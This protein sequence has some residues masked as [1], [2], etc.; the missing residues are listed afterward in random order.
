MRCRLVKIRFM[1]LSYFL[2]VNSILLFNLSVPIVAS[3]FKGEGVHQFYLK[4][5]LISNTSDNKT[6]N[7]NIIR[8]YRVKGEPI[9]LTHA[10]VTSNRAIYDLGEYLWNQG[11]D[12]WMPNMRSHGT[13]D[14]RSFVSPYSP[15]DYSFDSIVT[16]DWPFLLDYVYKET[17]KKV[18]IVGHSM[19]A[20]TWEQCLSGT[21]KDADGSLYV[22]DGLIKDRSSKVSSFTT[23][24]MPPDL[25]EVRSV[26]KSLVYP[27][28]PLLERFHIYVPFNVSAS[29]KERK[30]S[31]QLIRDSVVSLISPY[32]FFILP[33]GIISPKNCSSEEFE[34]L[35]LK[36]LS[37]AHSDYTSD[38][39][40]WMY[41]KYKSRDGG[42]HYDEN[43]RVEVPT[44]TITASEDTLAPPNYI[45]KAMSRYPD[46]TPIRLVHFIGAAHLDIILSKIVTKLG[47]EIVDFYKNLELLGVREEKVVNL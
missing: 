34:D 14:Q 9:I 26:I 35:V 39:I 19:G 43:K 31:S 45:K 33:G 5:E 18:H 20:M 42:V 30:L 47:R 8:L 41:H 17:G 24:A 10:A 7:M 4:K 13:P 3:N 12:V 40:R 27:L 38:L 28:L 29:G 6:L 37:A 23:I 11:F 2:L 32:I 36:G 16:E 15:G 25:E 21:S 22:S 44:L 46:S 1:G